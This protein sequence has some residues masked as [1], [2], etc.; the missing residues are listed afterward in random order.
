[1]KKIRL[2]LSVLLAVFLADTGIYFFYPNVAALNEKHP[3][4]TAFMRYRER[5]WRRE[6]LLNKKI[7]QRW[8]PYS[9]ISPFVKKAVLISE[10]DRFWHNN[11]FE[12]KA[13][14]AAM[15]KDIEAGKFEF[16]GSTITQQLAKNLWLSP[17]KNPLRKIKEAV[18][19]WRLNRD[20]PKRRILELY[21]NEAEWGD[22]IFGIGAA[23]YHYFRKPAS[24][25]TPMEAAR[26]AAALP[27][28]IK[29]PPTGS[30]RFVRTRSRAIYKIMVERGAIREL[31]KAVSRMEKEGPGGVENAPDIQNPI[32]NSPEEPGNGVSNTPQQPYQSPFSPQNQQPAP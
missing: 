28:P 18:L 29:F 16:G 20:L 22:G 7:I 14:E 6:G 8:V 19:T 4:K 13:I 31:D 32:Q 21:L 12:F 2:I 1:M 25:L 3:A 27:N 23:S 24:A 30:S 5:Q 11:G 15:L 9:R 26:L 10:D 17:A